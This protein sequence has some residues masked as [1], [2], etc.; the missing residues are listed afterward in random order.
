MEDTKVGDYVFIHPQHS[1]AF[2]RMWG[3]IE[4]ITDGGM[5]NI[6][7]KGRTRAFQFSSGELLTVSQY[8]ALLLTNV[9]D[10]VFHTSTGEYIYTSA[11]RKSTMDDR[12]ILVGTKAVHVSRLVPVTY[13]TRC[14]RET[15]KEFTNL[16]D[17]CQ[18][19]DEMGGQ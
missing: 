19:E 9:W 16:C 17:S 11:L 2:S 3:E 4:S 7:F 18:I 12:F 15:T 8:T 1:M 5:Y 6:K 10:K 14:H 13:C